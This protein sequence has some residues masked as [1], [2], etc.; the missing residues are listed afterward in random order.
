VFKKFKYSTPVSE[1]LNGV[2]NSIFQGLELSIAGLELIKNAIE[3]VP[4][5]E[6]IHYRTSL[7]RYNILKF[8]TTIRKI[9]QIFP[10]ANIPNLFEVLK[11]NREERA[12]RIEGR[13]IPESDFFNKEK[14]REKPLKKE[15][16][17]KYPTLKEDMT[18]EL[19]EEKKLDGPDTK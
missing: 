6:L 17:F 1:K 8:D 11:K 3:T 9:K 14:L 2:F 16:F 7:D 15:V 19:V 12:L 4:I 5:N 18:E 13:D 10:E